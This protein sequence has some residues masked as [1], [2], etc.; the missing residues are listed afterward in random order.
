MAGNS[1]SGTRRAEIGDVP[2]HWCVAPLSTFVSRITYGFT[3]PMP[4]TPDGP[5]MITAKDIHGGRIDYSTARHTSWEA[6]RKNLTEK[7]RPR[8][9]DILLTK[10]GSIGRIAI[11]DRED[12]CINQSVALIQPNERI[13]PRF[14]KFLL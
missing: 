10:D 6:Y 7:S 11:C 1:S 2:V 13:S 14:L 9:D 3:N 8:I 12:V 5:F 4:T